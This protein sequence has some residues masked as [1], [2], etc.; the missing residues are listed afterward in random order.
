MSQ[1]KTLDADSACDEQQ[2]GFH[3]KPLPGYRD[4]AAV[5]EICLVIC[6][7]ICGNL[8]CS[9]RASRLRVMHRLSAPGQG[10]VSPQGVYSRREVKH[11]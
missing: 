4:P 7:L 8:G 5:L 2:D 6:P 1:I 9:S 3:K 10:K 11:R